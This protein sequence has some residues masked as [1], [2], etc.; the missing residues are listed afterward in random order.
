M[1]Y[2]PA[3]PKP[4]YEKISTPGTSCNASAT[5]RSP[6][7]SM[8]VRSTT[9]VGCEVSPIGSGRRSFVTTSPIGRKAGPG[10]AVGDAAGAGA[11][12]RARS[13]GTKTE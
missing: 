7:A 13:A 10:L 5:V 6:Y 1:P 9:N 4:P 12:A 8:R 3:E 11:A 2:E